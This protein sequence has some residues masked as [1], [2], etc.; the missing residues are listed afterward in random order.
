MVKRKDE[1]EIGISGIYRNGSYEFTK[2]GVSN[3][4]GS[5]SGSETEVPALEMVKNESDQQ[6]AVA[7]KYTVSPWGP[8][9][10]LPNHLRFLF[11]NN[12][13]P[14]LLDFKVDMI[15]GAGYTLVD[16]ATGHEGTFEEEWAWMNDW[17]VFGYLLAQITDFVF[18]ENVFG[19]VRRSKTQR[20]VA[21]ILPVCAEQCRLAIDGKKEVNGVVTG[22][23]DS[24][25]G[26]F[27][28]YPLWDMFGDVRS[29]NLS[30]SIVM[31]Q[32]KKP[33]PGFRYYNYPVYIGA[34][35]SWIPVANKIPKMHLALLNNTL[36]AAYHVKIPMES[37]S[38]L[39]AE[40]EWTK[41][42]LKKYVS[43]RLKE[44]DNMVCGAENA[45]KTFYTYTLAGEKGTQL[46][47][48]IEMIENKQKEMSESH[49]QLFNDCNQA[50]TSA[51]QVQ[52]SLA[53]IQLGNKMSSGSEV[54]NAY[55]LHVKTRTPIARKIITDPINA[56]LRI[57]FPGTTARVAFKDIT[58]VKQEEN[59]NGVN[60]ET[61]V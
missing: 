5:R 25:G 31:Y 54:L 21:D 45:G 51:F 48:K 61:G 46:E 42:D 60:D 41:E 17:D 59:K 50:L 12:L 30:D 52:P 6:G 32:G 44:I 16:A 28:K 53:S 34:V 18:Y 36:M 20:F 22:N 37:L 8:D 27:T 33:T 49:L 2:K 47:W 3:R 9:N 10:L 29:G 56:A 7:G 26:D 43:E 13:V 38:K 11:E 57:N 15:F 23:Y 14:G 55:N 39:A 4:G 24:S 58:L 40:K 35:N 1:I 19:Q